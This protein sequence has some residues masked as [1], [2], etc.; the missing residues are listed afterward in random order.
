LDAA[1]LGRCLVAYEPVWAIG[2]RGVPAPPEHVRVTHAA[3]RRVLLERTTLPVPILYGGSV[4]ADNATRLATEPE[5][6]GLFIG[7]AAWSARGLAGIVRDVVAPR[8][9][10]LSV[11]TRSLPVS[12]A[13]TCR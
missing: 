4:N 5:V 9:N 6:D 3:L 11:R 8:S 13:A 2:E 7:R 10:R 1:A 12:V